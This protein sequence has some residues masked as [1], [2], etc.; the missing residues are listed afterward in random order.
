MRYG[1]TTMSRSSRAD[2]TEKRKTVIRSV[3]DLLWD[4]LDLGSNWIWMWFPDST[5]TTDVISAV[6]NMK[7]T[8]L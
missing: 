7:P 6:A 1:I 3:S 5:R 4:I 2:A 8:A